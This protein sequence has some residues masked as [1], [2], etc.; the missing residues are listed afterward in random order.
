MDWKSYYGAEL[1][2]PAGQESIRR[3][4]ERYPRGDERIVRILQKGGAVSFPHTSIHYAGEAIA[5]LVASLYRIGARRIVALGVL[6][7]GTLPPRQRELYA[8]LFRPTTS[9]RAQELFDIFKGAFIGTGPIATPFGELPLYR[10]EEA[11]NGV[12]REGGELLAHEFSLDTLFSLLTFYARE[13]SAAPI[14][15]LPLFVS[16]TRDPQGSFVTASRIARWLRGIVDGETALV[17]TGDLV[18]YGTAYSSPEEMASKPTD[19]AELQAFFVE[20]VRYALERACLGEYEA[21]YRLST[22]ELKSDQ[23][24]I[25][26]IICEYLGEGRGYELLQFELSDYSQIL[27]VEPPCVVASALVGFTEGL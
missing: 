21:F 8:E 22:E 1:Q 9:G 16:L 18:H 15:V 3:C 26:P 14:A 17:A 6:H 12:V 24:Q 13:R 23:R 19:A 2:S 11:G 27:Q 20:R 5:R 10:V 7:G 4:F 25:V